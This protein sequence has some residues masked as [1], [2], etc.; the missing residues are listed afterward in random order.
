MNAPRFKIMLLPH[1]PGAPTQ[2]V[3]QWQ[4]AVWGLGL[5]ALGFRDV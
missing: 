4:V 1:P 5:S 3:R 2:I